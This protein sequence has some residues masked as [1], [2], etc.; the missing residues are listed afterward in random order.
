MIKKSLA[1]AVIILIATAVA[2]AGQ[3][4]SDSPRPTSSAGRARPAAALAAS[5][6][7]PAD[8]A[9]PPTTVRADAAAE[10]DATGPADGD[11]PDDD[12]PSSPGGDI[13]HEWFGQGR[14]VAVLGDSLTVQAR[15]H[16]RRLLADDALKVAA[17]FGEGMAGG[18]LS[19]GIGSPIMPAVVREYAEDP[20]D[21]VVV[22]LGTNDVW[23]TGLGP[24][25]FER[26]WITMT[27]SFEGSCI[28]GVTVSETTE[29]A[30][31]DAGDAATVNRVIR[32]TADVV[33]DWAVLGA[34][35]RYTGPDHIHLTDD[36]QRRFAELI[37]RGVD[38]CER[39][40]GTVG[41]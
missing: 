12:R 14:A 22:A 18:P 5:S 2:V 26:S 31:Y 8:D 1:L 13:E 28:V 19:D 29:A 33:V 7:G 35:P 6:G 20:P 11:A 27:R 17:L 39:P 3:P 34:A 37:A 10:P 24:A 40:V 32:R 21:V 4:T 15:R 41:R 38:S 36:G 9:A 30:R 25:S 16:L 23:Q